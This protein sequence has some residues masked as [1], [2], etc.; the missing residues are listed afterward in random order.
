M[1][2]LCVRSSIRSRTRR[3]NAHLLSY[4][5]LTLSTCS[6]WPYEMA[7]FFVCPS[8][9]KSWLRF[10]SSWCSR[11]RTYPFQD[12]TRKRTY[13]SFQSNTGT[14]I[15]YRSELKTKAK[16][17]VVKL[18]SAV[19]TRD[20]ECGVA[21]GRLASIVEQVSRNCSVREIMCWF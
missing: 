16:R 10:S 4:S 13:R 12:K 2:P 15:A 18:G 1:A 11:L 17:V 3:Q 6:I 14:G 8:V 7:V 20:D 5:Q 9:Q 19:I 21:L